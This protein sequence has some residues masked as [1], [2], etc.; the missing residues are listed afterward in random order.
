MTVSKAKIN[1]AKV[2]IHFLKSIQ[3]L[4]DERLS[5]E[6]RSGPR[7]NIG[8]LSKFQKLCQVVNTVSSKRVKVGMASHF[9]RCSAVSKGPTERLLRNTT[10]FVFL[11][12]CHLK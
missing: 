1:D 5:S 11:H 9:I 7:P 10:Q 8:I 2:Y 3:T 12:T 4:E 6:A